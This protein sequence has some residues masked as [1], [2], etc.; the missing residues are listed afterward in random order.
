MKWGIIQNSNAM[1]IIRIEKKNSLPYIVISP[2]I[3][4]DSKTGPTPMALMCYM[5]FSGNSEVNIVHPS[6]IASVPLPGVN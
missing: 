5:L 4:M 6:I 2:I 3:P 1:I